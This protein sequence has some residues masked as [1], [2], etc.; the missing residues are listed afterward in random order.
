MSRTG[1]TGKLLLFIYFASLRRI[2]QNSGSLDCFVPYND[3]NPFCF[4]V[5]TLDCFTSLARTS[6]TLR[7]CEPLGYARDRLRE[8]IRKV[9][10]LNL[11]TFG[12]WLR[13]R[14]DEVLPRSIYPACSTCMSP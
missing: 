13:P 11:M 7:H 8:A 3:V 14:S 2:F 9:K 12:L 10:I 1:D 5:S 4:I 6:D